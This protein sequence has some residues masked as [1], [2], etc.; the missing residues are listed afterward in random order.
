MNIHDVWQRTFHFPDLQPVI[1]EPVDE[2]LTSDAGLL[3]LRQL[4]DH[5]GLTAG[6]EQQ[7]TDCR[8][9]PS[10]THSL[11]EMIRSRVF[12]IIAGYEDQNDH[13]A[14]RSDALFKLIA[15]CLPSD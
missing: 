15:G 13:D 1:V 14:L 10:V 5:L 4:D 7:L 11:L 3:P 8:F 12:G 6:F 2:Q 9:Q